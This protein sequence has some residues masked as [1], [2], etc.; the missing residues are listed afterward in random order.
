MS[1]LCHLQLL[2]HCLLVVIANQFPK[3]FS[4]AV[5]CSVD[6]FLA[7]LALGLSERYR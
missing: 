5:H 4:P 7:A 3:D 2:G 6:K 1:F